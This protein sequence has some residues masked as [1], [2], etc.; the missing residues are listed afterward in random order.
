MQ[1]QITVPDDQLD[2]L[3]RKLGWTDFVQDPNNTT[4][5]GQ[6]TLPNPIAQDQWVTNAAQTYLNN[7]AIAASANSAAE[8]ARQTAIAA[9]TAV[10]GKIMAVVTT[11]AQLQTSPSTPSGQSL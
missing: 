3:A 8:Q 11:P 10:F 1:G 9:T 2:A 6:G 7:E 4:P 5:I